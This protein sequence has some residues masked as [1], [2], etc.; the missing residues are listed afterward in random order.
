MY[1][2]P[3]LKQTLFVTVCLLKEAARQ[4]TAAADACVGN[5]TSV[6]LHESTCV[7]VLYKRLLNPR[8]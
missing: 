1:N 3:A 7:S 5:I 8:L 4:P 2:Q 6:F